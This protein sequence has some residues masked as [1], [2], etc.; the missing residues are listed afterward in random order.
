M[1]DGWGYTL[2]IVLFIIGIVILVK[3]ADFFVG[4]A[5]SV[6]KKFKIS[7][8]VIGLT[9]VSFGTSAPEAAVSLSDSL[10]TNGNSTIAMSNIVGSN[11]V[12]LLAIL[13]VCA[14]II[15]LKIKKSLN[16]KEFPLLIGATLL[17]I[18]FSFDNFFAGYSGVNNLISR[19]DA[20]IMLFGFVL[21]CYLC[22]KAA[23][24]GAVEDL[25]LNAGQQEVKVEEIVEYPLWKSLL[26]LGIG[27]AAIILSAIFLVTDP[28]KKIAESIGISLGLN[29][30]DVTTLVGL[31]VVAV[32]TSLPE[33][34]TSVVAAKKGENEIAVGNVIGSNIFNI[35]FILG[36]SGLFTTLPVDAAILTDMLFSFVVT[37]IVFILAKKGILSRKN[38]LFIL[39]IYLLYLTYIIIRV[40]NPSIVIPV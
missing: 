31:T 22:V 6:A 24:T 40:Y 2:N 33:L 8:L 9:V 14:L 32:G 3:G 19:S 27:L 39:G 11:I 4:G 10:A 35:L 13:G 30:V 34:V 17:L 29:P 26:F 37:I 36:L 38:G 5:A 18:I 20:L 15:P 25:Q 16:K 1:L 21:F 28:A 23:K 12:N 7:S